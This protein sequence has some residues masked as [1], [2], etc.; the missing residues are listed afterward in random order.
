MLLLLDDLQEDDA[1][2][3]ARRRFTTSIEFEEECLDGDCLDNEDKVDNDVNDSHASTQVGKCL[4]DDDKDRTASQADKCLD[5]DTCVA[6]I[7]CVA[8]MPAAPG[9]FIGASAL[10][11]SFAAFAAL[12]VALAAS[13]CAA[14]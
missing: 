8:A 7:A 1:T 14:A 10:A 12:L 5:K 6:A 13:F 9:K 11:A 4:G 3:I 2:A